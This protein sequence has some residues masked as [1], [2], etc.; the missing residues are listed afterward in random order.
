MKNV[1]PLSQLKIDYN[2][3]LR[4]LEKM[5][6]EAMARD[7]IITSREII[8]QSRRVDS[9]LLRLIEEEGTLKTRRR[10]K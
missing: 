1:I 4:L 9:L 5:V 3:E 10:E 6:G 2:A 7:E 8:L